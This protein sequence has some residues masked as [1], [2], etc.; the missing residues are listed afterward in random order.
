MRGIDIR[1]HVS[2]L[3]RAVSPESPSWPGVQTP[4]DPLVVAG[5]R[6]RV[7]GSA[8][9]EGVLGVRGARQPDQVRDLLVRVGADR[10][11]PAAVRLAAD[12]V[13][14]GGR[15]VLRAAVVCGLFVVPNDIAVYKLR[16]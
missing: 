4:S 1:A 11:V 15:S 14:T 9:R 10:G 12:L 2:F 8:G 6:P 7:P 3:V 5:Y 13:G 16:V